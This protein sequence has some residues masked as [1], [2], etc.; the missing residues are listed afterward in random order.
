MEFTMFSLSRLIEVFKVTL[1]IVFGLSILVNNGC[2]SSTS[3]KTPPDAEPKTMTLTSTSFSEGETIPSAY[4]CDGANTKPQFT[5]DN[6]PADTT[7]FVL[8]MDDVYTS[9]SS[10][11]LEAATR[12][13]AVYN[14]PVGTTTFTENMVL[15]SPIVR[16]V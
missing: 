5:W 1:P 9:P 7:G 16:R 2:S 8:I 11:S 13:W 3:P 4:T 10:A 12:H 15:P 14:I 6:F